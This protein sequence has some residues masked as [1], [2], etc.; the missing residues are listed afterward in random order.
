MSDESLKQAKERMIKSHLI[1]RGIKN[2]RVLAAFRKVAREEFV[3]A[4]LTAQAYQDRPLPIGEGQTIS[5]PYI[6]A[7]MVQA[8]NPRP[9]DKVLEVGIG[10]GYAAAILAEIVTVVY[11]VERYQSLVEE[12]EQRLTNLGYDNLDLKEGDGTTGWEEYA[13]YDGILVSAAAPEIPKSLT[14]QLTE[15]GNLVIP[16]GTKA[17][18][19]LYQIQKLDGGELDRTEL[20]RVRFVPLLGEEGW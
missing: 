4:K 7:E 19:E 15:G 17:V 1:A 3:P 6:V 5:Q 20:G 12:A 8:L 11:G 10:S 18:Q 16:V 14:E 2:E 9:S 13:P